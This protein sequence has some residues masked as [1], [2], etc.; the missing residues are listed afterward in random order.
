[1]CPSSS[2]EFTTVVTGRDVLPLKDWK[3]STRVGNLQI[4]ASSSW[5]FWT[6]L[7]VKGDMI[8]SHAKSI[9]ASLS[10]NITTRS[11]RSAS[12]TCSS[13]NKLKDARTYAV[14][15]PFAKNTVPGSA[16]TPPSKALV[17]MTISESPSLPR[18]SLNLVTPTRYY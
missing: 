9:D 4:G 16:R 8:V 13:S 14:C 15:A 1:M 12:F 2:S 5:T 10:F 17:R 18:R 6:T 3:G 7:L 11:R